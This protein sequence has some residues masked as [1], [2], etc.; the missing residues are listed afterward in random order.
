MSDPLSPI[1]VEGGGDAM[2]IVYK[3]GLP[4]EDE[5]EFELEL[6]YMAEILYVAVQGEEA[7][8]WARVVP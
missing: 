8:M 7:F 2:R 1:R 4:L 5:D 3:Y 6:P